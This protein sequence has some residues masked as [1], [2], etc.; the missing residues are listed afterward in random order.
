MPTLAPTVHQRLGRCGERVYVDGLVTGA[1]VVLSVDGVEFAH[2]ATAHSHDFVVPALAPA[3]IVKA[4]Q[5]T[6]AGFS[7]WSPDVVVEDATVPPTSAPV[8]PDEVGACS[9]C[10]RVTNMVP[11]CGVELRIEGSLVGEGLTNRHGEA[12]VGVDLT[13]LKGRQGSTLRARMLVC[14]ALGPRAARAITSEPP[15]PKPQV[16]GPLFGCQSVVGV[17]NLRPGARCRF[18]SDRPA[19]LGSIC[20][21][22]PAVNVFVVR[23]LIVGERVRAR[24]YWDANP[25]DD[26][27]DPSGREL[28]VSPDDRIK[29]IVREALIEGDQMIRAENQISGASLV[30]R[31]RSDDVQPAVEFG[32]RPASVEQE[33]GLNERLKAGNIVSVVQTL[34]GVSRESDPVVVQPLPP[35]VDAPVIVPPLLACA[36]SVQVSNLHSGA[37]VRVFMD[38]ITIGVAWAG[39]ASSLKVTAAPALVSG[40]QVTARQQVGSVVSPDSAPVRVGSAR[41]LRRPRVLAPLALGDTEV[42][43]SNV[44]PGS[45]LVVESGGAII[46]SVDAAESV[47]RITVTPV[48]GEISVTARFCSRTSIVGTATPIE[49]PCRTRKVKVG[50]MLRTYPAWHVPVTADGGDF[51]MPFEGQL[52][53]PTSGGNKFDSKAKN[54]PLVIIAHGYWTPGVESFKGYDYLAH[55]L[56]QWGMVV[57]SLNMDEVTGRSVPPESQQYSRGEIILHAIDLLL[58]DAELSGRIDWQRIGLVGHS[59]GGEGVVVAQLLNESEGR[60]Y[61]ISGVVSISPTRWRPEAVLRHTKYMQ[62]SGSL[63]QLTSSMTGSDS[64]AIFSGFRIYDRAWRPK[65]HFWVY[66]LRHNPFNRIWPTAGDLF[67]EG[68]IDVA[69]PPDD[70]ERAA[71]CLINA[72]LQD[73][74]AGQT[75]YAGYMEGTIFPRSLAHLQIHTQHSKHPRRIV[76][77]NFGD[78]DEQVPLVGVA[79]DKFTNSRGQAVTG[80]ALLAP[81]DDVEH[82]GVAHSPH[83][84]K[85]VELGWSAD[86]VY[87]STTGGLGGA[88]TDVIALRIGQFYEDNALNPVAAD[89]DA[90][91]V[92]HDGV[93]EAV[94]RLGAVAPI[95]YPD[96]AGHVLCP[97]RTVR[98]PLDAFKA[99]N[100][101]LNLNNIQTVALRF[102]ARPSGHILVDDLEVG[103]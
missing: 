101:E 18:E 34:C 80:H 39:N 91:V 7:P 74:L 36:R 58:G 83:N 55:H 47:A 1:E 41:A 13:A 26:K 51:D 28:V 78:A 65:T 86:A 68:L 43:V 102:A 73:A 54:L 25:C 71:R 89:A 82:T 90:F 85:G 56:V 103:A 52:Y 42:W 95:P 11:G 53:F 49:S 94:V 59:M 45:H 69:L 24:C 98:I 70:H 88:L 67:E 3:A 14:G 38:G 77:D 50:E 61:G 75:A 84:T 12:C 35:I 40:A 8:L 63:D 37:L 10:V 20:S 66:G 57:F 32:P 79:L 31:I 22:W 16:Q 27:G 99:V 9:Q 100:P 44:I 72:F 60:G 4:R 15:L 64:A 48:T 81:F 62:I 93:N 19:D 6:G 29:P 92:L 21:C 33:I 46:G 17:S 5:D 87:R 96:S 76:L 30:I 23:R 2:T 97:L